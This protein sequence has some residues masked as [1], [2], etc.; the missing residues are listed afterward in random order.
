MLSRDRDQ[1]KLCEAMQGRTVMILAAALLGAFV[2]QS[3]F[4]QTSGTGT[5]VS[6]HAQITAQG[7]LPEMMESQ[8]EGAS[9]FV[10][11]SFGVLAGLLVALSSA[12]PAFAQRNQFGSYEGMDEEVKKLDV[13][14]KSKGLLG[15]LGNTKGDPKWD[16]KEK[17]IYPNDNI[18]E[19]K[20]E[21]DARAAKSS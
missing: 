13:G 15:E 11:L 1:Q 12:S 5:K 6:S 10:S 14:A 7:R 2:W 19:I 18:E 9:S 3:A 16:P 4:V 17:M 8:D 20:E 21:R